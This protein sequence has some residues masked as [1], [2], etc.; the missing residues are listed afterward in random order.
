LGA[1][2]G[3]KLL[4][5]APFP[6]PWIGGSAIQASHCFSPTISLV[7]SKKSYTT[8]VQVFPSWSPDGRFVYFVSTDDGGALWR[9]RMGGGRPERIISLRALSVSTSDASFSVSRENSIILSRE[10]GSDQIYAAD[11]KTQRF[12]PL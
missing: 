4:N 2:F 3:L 9:I 6:I 1:G 8:D 5:A 12:A 11:W 7:R 10:S